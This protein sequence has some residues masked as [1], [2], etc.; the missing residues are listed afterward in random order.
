MAYILG[1]VYADQN[2]FK[3]STNM[4]EEAEQIAS[5][6]KN[7]ELL[8]KINNGRG[9]WY[10]MQSDFLMPPTIIPKHVNIFN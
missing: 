5:K 2:K 3:E 1:F 7:H 9:G 6:E 10:F 4:Y 8:G